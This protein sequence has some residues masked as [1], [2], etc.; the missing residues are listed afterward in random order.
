MLFRSATGAQQTLANGA[1]GEV[2]IGGGASA[3]PSW[4]ASPTLT[5]LTTTGNIE[6]GHASDTTIARASAGKV[7]IEGNTI[8]VVANTVFASLPSAA[9]ATTYSQQYIVTDYLGGPTLVYSNGTNWIPVTN[10]QARYID[11]TDVSTAATTETFIRSWTIPANFLKV[12]DSF[13]IGIYFS[14]SS[15][16]AAQTFYVH[17]GTVG[18][19]CT[20]DTNLNFSVAARISSAKDRKST[21]LNSSH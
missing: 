17:N 19:D 7:T 12:G 4:T 3:L 9:S 1:S 10:N 6:L 13:T 8:P 21:R 2:L 11:D 16:S 5:T 15:N 18:G 20:S 14:K